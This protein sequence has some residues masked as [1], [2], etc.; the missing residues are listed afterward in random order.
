MANRYSFTQRLGNTRY[1]VNVHFSE[2]ENVVCI[3][4]SLE[5]EKLT[6]PVLKMDELIKLADYVLVEADGAK[7]LPLKAHAEHEPVIP[8]ISNQTILVMGV[9]CIGKKIS[10]VCHRPEIC[11]DLLNK[12]IDNIVSEKLAM[13]LV[14][15]EGFGDRI[16]INKVETEEDMDKAVN[17]AKETKRLVIAGSL[18]KKEYTYL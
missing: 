18:W 11:A 15:K 5:N 7:H 12:D 1:C 16:Y 3:G 6:M 10:E 17:M 2:N 14:D 4:G 9:D 13:E 8:D